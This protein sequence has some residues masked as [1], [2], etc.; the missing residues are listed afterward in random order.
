VLTLAAALPA[1]YVMARYDFPGKSWVRAAVTVPFVLPTVV[2]GS[3]FLALIGPRGALGIDL[4]FSIWAILLAHVF[5]NYAVVVRTVG[6]LWSHLD[7]DVESAARVLGASRW[8]AFVEVTLPMLRPAIAAASSIVFLFTITSFGV[9]LILGG[10]RFATVEVEI[11]RQTTTFLNLGVA[12][13]LA[14]VQLVG[15]A[16][17]LRIYAGYQERRAVELHLRPEAEVARRPRSA[18]QW[19]VVAGTLTGMLILLGLPLLVLIERSL[20][21]GTGY[22]LG[23]Y[24]TLGDDTTALFVPPAEAVRNSLAFA[25]IATLIAVVIGMMAAAVIAYRRDRVSRWF[26]T[27]L[28]LPLGTS[29]VTIGFGF[30]IA[31]DWPVD[32][33]TSPMLIPIAHALVALPLV[34]RIAVPVMRSVRSRLREAAAVLG[35]GPLRAWREVDLP[36]VSRAALIGAGFAFAISLGEFGATTFIVRPDT[37]TLPVAIFRFLSQPGAANFGRAMAMSVLLMALTL[38]AVLLIERFRIGDVGEF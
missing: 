4:A 19:A 2:V 32:L 13:V 6:G 30:L 31:L 23:N 27:L 16:V 22:G 33:R 26:D 38:V 12:A 28:M 14:I 29:A 18:G 34:V 21:E 25:V 8:R 1:A 9:I 36:L 20:W 17:I 15:V 3:A 24:R 11:Y 37:P 10:P 5:Y 7:P 35:A